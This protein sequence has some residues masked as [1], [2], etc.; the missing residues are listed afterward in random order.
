MIHLPKH[1]ENDDLQ[2]PKE[3]GIPTQ[4]HVQK[5]QEPEYLLA[6]SKCRFLQKQEKVRDRVGRP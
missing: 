5:F 4:G 6:S 3:R 2:N 1:P